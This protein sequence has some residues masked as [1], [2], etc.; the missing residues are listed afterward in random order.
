MFRNIRGCFLIRTVCSVNEFAFGFVG[1]RP[2]K[3]E[4]AG[5]VLVDE[6]EEGVQ[7]DVRLKRGRPF[8][9]P[10]MNVHLVC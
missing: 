2:D 9:T 5:S 3:S 10:G 4:G 6:G 8:A 1:G 7:E